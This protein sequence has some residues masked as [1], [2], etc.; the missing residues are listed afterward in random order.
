MG[1]FI[2]GK[3][4]KTVYIFNSHLIPPIT[5]GER[6]DYE[7]GRYLANIGYNVRFLEESD[8]FQFKRKGLT[9][10]ILLILRLNNLS[11]RSVMVFDEGLH[12]RMNLFCLYLRLFTNV[13]LFAIVHHLTSPLKGGAINRRIDR[14]SEWL[15]LRLMH[16]IIVNSRYTEKQVLPFIEKKSIRVIHPAINLKKKHSRKKPS[17]GCVNILFVGY[18]ERRKGLD[19][20]VRALGNIGKIDREW[21][22]RIVGDTTIFP[23]YAKNCI[24]L[25]DK[26]GISK[27]VRFLGKLDNKDLEEEYNNADIFVLPSFHE[28]YGMVI[29][30]AASYG[31]PIISTDVGAIPELVENGKSAILLEPGDVDALRDALVMLI[32]D[33]QLRKRLGRSALETV[34]FNYNWER[35]GEMFEEFI[36]QG[37]YSDKKRIKK[38]KLKV[39]IV[40]VDLSIGG[41]EEITSKLAVNLPSEYFNVHFVC[42]KGGGP[43][44]ENF[45]G[46]SVKLHILNCKG[47]KIFLTPFRIYNLLVKEKI[48]ILHGHPGA[49]ARLA[50]WFVHTPIIISSTHNTYVDKKWHQIFIDKIFSNITDKIISVSNAVMDFEI[51]QIGI[52]KEKYITIYNGVDIDRFLNAPDKY[53]ARDIL[54]LNR[55]MIYITSLG[56]FHRQKGMD[57]FIRACAIIRDRNPDVG[58][59]LAGYGPLETELRS[60]SEKLGLSGSMK[61]LIAR[62]DPEVILSASDI[63]VCAS[64]WG[65]FEIV[66]AEAMA[67]VLPVVATN[68]G[69]IPEV[70]VDGETGYLVTVDCHEEIAEKVLRLLG[71]RDLS[72]RLGMAGRERVIRIFSIKRMVDKTVDLYWKFAQKKI[73]VY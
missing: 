12:K 73:M 66:L 14:F 38:R 31:L 62:R 49:F 19:I 50:G 69:P 13:R 35:V 46:S 39:M 63:F 44:E 34:D 45:K 25:A 56:R 41:I 67:S 28:G 21:Q 37:D 6:Y 17:D 29:K 53:K 32:S 61:F 7:V 3:I 11:K 70:V 8:V 65:G 68:V 27:N 58:F 48:D 5:G 55:D 71:D 54:G 16:K 2:R 36:S 20:L 60:L 18:L 43:L 33:S 15:F 4:N 1:N 47:I 10:S 64:R 51:K 72:E 22:L 9:D 59:I 52:K 24:D 57:T 30:E 42:Y 40:I 23:D 26:F